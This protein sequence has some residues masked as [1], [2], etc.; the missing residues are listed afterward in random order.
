M[1]V[2][3]KIV[4]VKKISKCLKNNRGKKK[5]KNRRES[6]EEQVN[7]VYQI[8]CKNNTSNSLRTT[9]GQGHT[10]YATHRCKQ[11]THIVSF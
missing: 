9:S 5:K 2:I 4:T 3:T 1:K 7:P 10:H 6:L 8:M 11:Q